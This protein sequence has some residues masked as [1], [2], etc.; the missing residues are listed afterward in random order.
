MYI[1]GSIISG[2]ISIG[3]FIGCVYT[4]ISQMQK[5]KKNISASGIV[6]GI[7]KRIFNAGSSGVYCPIVEFISNAGETIRFRSSFGT[8]P[9]SNK[10]G[11]A[12][13]VLY[14][15]NNPEEA[16]IET[17]I[18][19]Y[20]VPGCLL[21]FTVGSCFFSLMFLGLFLLTQNI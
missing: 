21:L 8:M 14:N 9:A 6:V 4:L 20:F 10:E 15:P 12:V 7:E 17:G 19:R 16:E 3:C 1:L 5:R 11:D 13:K 2:L 18:S